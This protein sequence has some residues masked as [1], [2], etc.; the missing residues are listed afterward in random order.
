MLMFKKRKE[1]PPILVS[2]PIPPHTPS[3]HA[4]D[5]QLQCAL[6][7]RLPS[8]LRNEIYYY[9]FT[10]TAPAEPSPAT[11]EA[12]PTAFSLL[13]TCRLI[14]LE[15]SHLAYATHTFQLPSTLEPTFVAM[16]NRTAHIPPSLASA[17][18]RVGCDLGRNCCHN[19]QPAGG[20]LVNAM[21]LFPG[22]QYFEVHITPLVTTPA[23][24]RAESS[25]GG[26]AQS[27]EDAPPN[28]PIFAAPHWFCESVVDYAATRGHSWQ[29]GERWSAEW[30]QSEDE[31]MYDRMADG[32]VPDVHVYPLGCGVGRWLHAVL[33]QETGRRIEVKVV[34]KPGSLLKVPK[35]VGPPPEQLV[36]GTVPADGTLQM[37]DQGARA[38]GYEPDAKYWED[39]RSRVRKKASP[40]WKL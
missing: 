19:S 33:V 25:T 8:E 34:I 29:A 26:H 6:L 22:L 38:F 20:F 12:Q 13:Q 21:L 11:E 31:D 18:T 4:P 23:R 3:T 28:I 30:L 36:P 40:W 32:D 1:Q 5:P 2:P 15:A 24:P 35:R 7:S 39:T 14:H 10:A 17:I 27:S 9:T 16:R 37:L